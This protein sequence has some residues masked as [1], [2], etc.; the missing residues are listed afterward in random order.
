MATNLREMKRTCRVPGCTQETASRY[1]PYCSVH[2]ARLRRHGAVDQDGITAAD[3]KPYLSKVNA[4]IEK[5]RDSPA[6][7]QLDGRWLTLV[8]H[9]NSVIA[10]YEK[11]RASPRHEVKAAHEVVKIAGAAQAREVVETAL[12]MFIMQEFEPRR[13]RSDDAFRV[14]LVRRVRALANMNA[15]EFYDHRADK[16]RRVYREVSPRAVAVMGH[17]LSEA[18]GV[19]GLR[20][21]RLERADEERERKERL[22]LH[23]AL[24]ELK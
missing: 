14:Q 11:G 13:F 1:S 7:G 9:A 21:A 10:A 5:N 4:R 6:W 19:A 18:F 23:R 2:K 8:D 17:W 16:T 20:L 3:L 24:E 22:A 15:G 12:A